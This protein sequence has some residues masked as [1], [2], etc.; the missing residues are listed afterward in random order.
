M[1]KKEG[2]RN[3]GEDEKRPLTAEGIRHQEYNP[4]APC[5]KIPVDALVPYRGASPLCDAILVL[6]HSPRTVLEP[7]CSKA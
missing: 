6:S 1:N 7:Y 4:L 2:E 3:R 5:I